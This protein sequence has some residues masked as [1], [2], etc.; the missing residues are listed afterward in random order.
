MSETT[1]AAIELQQA[2]LTNAY[3]AGDVEH[4]IVHHLNLSNHLQF[5]GAEPATVLIHR[6]A[7][8]V[9]SFQSG[10]QMLN[11]ALGALAESL[12]QAA[13]GRLS[14]PDSFTALCRELEAGAGVALEPVAAKLA[15]DGGASGEEAFRAVIGLARRMLGQ[16]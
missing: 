5:A 16:G 2:A 6:L 15:D 1:S 8:A 3:R 10:S 9:L 12:A 4:C 13:P 11:I 7:A 14:L